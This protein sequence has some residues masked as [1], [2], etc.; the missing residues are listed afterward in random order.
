MSWQAINEGL[1]HPIFIT[2]LCKV[3]DWQIAI[4]SRNMDGQTLREMVQGVGGGRND[5]KIQESEAE[6]AT[7][8]DL[9]MGIL[10]LIQGDWACDPVDQQKITN[11]H[12]ER[13]TQFKNWLDQMKNTPK[14]KKTFAI[15]GGSK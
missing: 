7:S 13:Q 3:N 1:V 8:V 5:E 6:M 14:S 4:D 11:M 9:R 10:E 12:L 15:Q 2:L